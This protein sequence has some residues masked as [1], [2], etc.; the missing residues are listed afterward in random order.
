M[1]FTLRY[2][3]DLPA[4]TQSKSRTY[5]KH[6][7][8]K[9]WARQLAELWR[10]DKRLNVIPLDKIPVAEKSERY[11]YDVSRPINSETRF[12]FKVVVGGIEFIPMV[13]SNRYMR[14]E[15]SVRLH[16]Y[17]GDDFTGRLLSEQGDID[18]RIKT[19]F[20]SLR[21]PQDDPELPKNTTHDGTPFFCL[22]ED[23][24]LITKLV[25]ETRRILEPRPIEHG[26]NWTIADIDVRLTPL[27]AMI[28]NV[29]LLFP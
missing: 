11:D 2:Q 16:R 3:G 4:C 17:E 10:L 6:E 8:R 18:N 5:E 20:D 19:L 24:S 12:F 29:E 14:C 23:D 21:I 25:I 9:V 22:L 27:V 13:L 28:A 1:E 15:L 7:I 26:D